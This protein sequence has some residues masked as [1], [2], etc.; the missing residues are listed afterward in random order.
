MRG[1]W[2]L[3]VCCLFVIGC[4]GSSDSPPGPL[5]KH[6][7]DM[8]IAR[9]PLDQKGTVVETQNKWSIAKMENANAE[10]NVQEA[11]GQVFQARNDAKAAKLN[12]DNAISAKKT[13]EQS[14]DMNRMNN[15]QKDLR[16]AEDSHKAANER[17][18]Y[19]EVY[20]A[21]L[22]RFHRYT[23]EN[24]YWHEAQYENAKATLAK[25]NNIQP[26]GIN[27]EDFPK[28]M[29]EREKR[30]MSSKDKAEAEKSKAVSARQ[31]W[32]SAQSLADKASGRTGT[33]YDPMAP[34]EGGPTA[35]GGGISQE[36]P[37]VVQPLKSNPTQP[38]PGADAGS[39][40]PAPAPAPQ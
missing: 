33:L 1:L 32:L 3:V 25:A 20:R 16:A 23:Q 21:Y 30:T 4:G 11:D 36:K 31:T 35:A 5:A 37:E 14:A 29:A 38:G 8:H 17:A 12:V 9:I 18:K 19:F 6:F 34:K 15:A 24:M 40:A 10:A 27:Y 2:Q 39:A 26:K 13:A 28:Q 22:K 7:D